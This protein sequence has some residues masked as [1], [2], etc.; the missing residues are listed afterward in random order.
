M[1]DQ[2]SMLAVIILAVGVSVHFSLHKVEEGY[3]GIYYRG[4]ALL[5]VTSQPGFHMMIPVLTT[6]KA[7]QTTLQTDEV[8]N[9]P[10]GTSGGVMIY[11]ERIEVV[12]KLDPNSV[13]DVVRNF[14]AD[15]DKTLIFN[16]VHHELNQFCSAHTLHEV[17]IDLFDQIDENLSTA[18][19]NDLNELAPGLKVNGVRVTKPKIPEAI[20]KNYELMEA[21]KS[22]FLIAEQHQKVVE[23]EA[24]TARR[25]AVIEAE[26]EAH[27]AKIQYEQKIMEKESL[28]KIELIE[29]SIHKAKQQTKAE[30]DYYHLKKQA[31]ANK[32]LLTKE[33]LELKK[34][35]ALALNNKI[36]FGNDIPN[37]FLQANVG[38]SF[39]K[40]VQVE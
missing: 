3:V 36:Y 20:R 27:V 21:E 23:K 38:E 40:N 29:D 19:Q 24:E 18:L 31:E 6:Y 26:K 14:T 32:L 2:T 7:I 4:G 25:K 33:Y 30:A 5:P 15:Y 37:M 11:F 8:K 10:C 17:Y 16:K 39:S 28:Q 1:A 13:L 35:E 22:K 9:V 12:N 34:Y